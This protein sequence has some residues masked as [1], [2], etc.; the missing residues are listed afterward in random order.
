[1]ISVAESTPHFRRE[2]AMT[3]AGTI[4]LLAWTQIL[5]TGAAGA[6]GDSSPAEA[7][8]PDGAT[9][10]PAANDAPALAAS[11]GL[12]LTTSGYVDSRMLYQRARHGASAAS[13][14]PKLSNLT[15]GSIQLKLRLSPQA[16]VD[17]D[18]SFF[19]QWA[20]LFA[21]DG[22]QDHVA[23][24]PQVV[25]SELFGSYELA[26]S[27]QVTAGKKRIVW[28][29]GLAQNPSDVINP[30]KDPTDPTSQRAGAWLVRVEMPFERFT[31]SWV[32]AAKVLRQYAGLPTAW[33]YYPDYPTAEAASGATPD[34]RDRQPHYALAGRAYAL[35]ADTDFNLVY[36]FT[37]LYNDRFRNKQ[38]V[39]T[40]LSH[41]FGGLE[42]HVEALLQAGS[43]RLWPDPACA[44]DDASLQDCVARGQPLATAQRL[45]DR[46]LTA[47]VLAGGR[48][49]FADTSMLSLE[50]VFDGEGL[51]ERGFRDYVRLLSF[52]GPLA[53]SD[54]AAAAAL[55]SALGESAETDPGSPARYRFEALRRHYLFAS[56]SKPQVADDFTLGLALALSLTD[57][58]GQL[59]PSV[60]WAPR[61]W[62]TLN[63]TA[64]VGLP[65]PAGC[66]FDFGRHRYGELSLGGASWSAAL[67]ARVYY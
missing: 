65:A 40:S 63:A 43:S 13:D 61:E 45:D 55:Q 42:A 24:R 2:D 28:G 15:E 39:A 25:M 32:A 36:A 7:L 5:V 60:T 34:D 52:G 20:G 27:L 51:D 18:V 58:S 14:L 30:P 9:P 33:I 12:E 4:L 35:I 66:G 49:M 26:P 48:Y 11:S 17:Y 31:L 19:W 21:E 46:A 3:A 44:H 64:T 56:Y 29:P 8:S 10:S 41:A 37:N 47:K 22:R 54:P 6:S 53:A 1:M 57:F 23:Y 62:L 67:S 16:F 38:R 59:V 50:Y